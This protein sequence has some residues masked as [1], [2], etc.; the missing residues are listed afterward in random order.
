MNS[1]EP[2][3]SVRYNSEIVITM[4]VYVA[5]YHLGPEK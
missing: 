3:K 4:K 2:R 5:R 1:T